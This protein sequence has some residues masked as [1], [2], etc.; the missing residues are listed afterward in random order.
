MNN[1]PQRIRARAIRQGQDGGFTF[2]EVVIALAVMASAAGI[3]I[4]MQGAALRR[5]VRDSNA[6]QA[7]LA[8]RRV[9]ASIEAMDPKNFTIQNQDNQP[10]ATILQNLG[11]TQS[12]DRGDT[13]PM[14]AMTASLVVEDWPIPLLQGE[15]VMKRV[16]LRVVWGPG[17]DEALEVLYLLPD[18]TS[19]Q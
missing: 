10:I 17:L 11:I 8:T 12:A 13:G 7:M 6:Q 9:M 5:T 16:I 19:P 18:L 3:I 2:I 15:A 4:G 1:S 14:S